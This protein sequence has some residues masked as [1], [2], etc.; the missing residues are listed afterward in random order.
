MARIGLFS[1]WMNSYYNA[2]LPA[3]AGALVAGAL[4]RLLRSPSS[5]V[6]AAMGLGALVLANSRPYEG[7]LLCSTAAVIL[8]VK[9]CTDR[10]WRSEFLRRAVL[11]LVL[12]VG[13]GGATMAYYNWRVYGSPWTLPYTSNRTTYAVAPMFVWQTPRPMPEYRH[14]VMRDFFVG[15]ELSLFRKATEGYG[16]PL[17]WLLEFLRS[18]VFFLFPLLSFAFL[19]GLGWL[20]T[21]RE[22]RLAWILFLVSVA[23]LGLLAFFMAH[24]VAAAVT[25]FYVLLMQSMRLARLRLWSSRSCGVAVV[26]NIAVAAVVITIIAPAYVSPNFQLG[27]TWYYAFPPIPGREDIIHKLDLQPGRD[28]VIVHYRPDHPP[29]NEWVYNEA[30][31]DAAGIVWAREMDAANNRDLISYFKGRRVWLLDA[32]DA[33][34]RLSPY[35]DLR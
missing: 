11:P 8:L 15:Y 24:Y 20:V 4:P 22:I 29:M 30:D 34:P 28:L 13:I 12:F 7:F 25:T 33:P 27:E 17:N 21:D 9:M 18:W 10:G 3:A 6:A 14:Q 26:R 32:D 1:Y 2:S 19:V 16:I 31:I 5:S 35:P 23:G